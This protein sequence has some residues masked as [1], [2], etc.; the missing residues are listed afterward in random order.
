MGPE[1]AQKTRIR[2]SKAGGGYRASA[3]QA[4]KSGE[5]P[6]EGDGLRGR[7]VHEHARAKDTRGIG[8]DA[9]RVQLLQPDA[10]VRTRYAAPARHGPNR[11]RYRQRGH[12]IWNRSGIG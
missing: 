10:R 6:G 3:L 2:G 9:P 1:G 8:V 7:N 5:C 11:L 12:E 4:E